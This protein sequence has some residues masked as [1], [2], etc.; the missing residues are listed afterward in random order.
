[1]KL[2]ALMTVYNE[3]EFIDYAIRAC[4]P[5]VDNLVIVEGSY[6]EMQRINGCS[7][8]SNDGTLDILD[9][10]FSEEKVYYDEANKETDKDQRNYGLDIVKS[11]NADWLV[12]VDGDEVYEPQT[13]DLIKSSANNMEKS[14]KYAAY[15]NS[16]TFVNDFK[17]YAVQKFP[18]LFRVTEDCLFVNDNFMEWPKNNLKWCPPH[19]ISLPYVNY[20]HFAFCKNLERFHQKRKWWENR[21]GSRLGDKFD[22]GWNSD[23]NGLIG[24]KNHVLYNFIGKYPEIMKDHPLYPREEEDE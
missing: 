2:V 14:N 23:E 1:M 21:F 19:V 12:I 15:F 5:H 18:R 24:D 11:L 17:H 3:A 8:R 20:Y 16:Y 4:L 10:Y 22:Y 7:P 6:A 13:F 9:K